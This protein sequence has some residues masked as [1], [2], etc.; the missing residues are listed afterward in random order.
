[1]EA[2]GKLGKEGELERTAKELFY[3]LGVGQRG[4]GTRHDRRRQNVWESRRAKL[5]EQLNNGE[6][7]K[8][9]YLKVRRGYLG[10]G[11]S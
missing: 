5:L 4:L 6:I 10:P 9:D 3:N 7:T 1:M 2:A 8:E 11:K